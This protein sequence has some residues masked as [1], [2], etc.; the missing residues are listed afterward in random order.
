M[1]QHFVKKQVTKKEEKYN[2]M[3]NAT[4]DDEL[5]E[6]SKL[7]QKEQFAFIYQQFKNLW[8]STPDKQVPGSVEN[9]SPI[10]LEQNFI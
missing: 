7:I 9:G 3:P 2:A 5:Y 1:N 8:G 6:Y 4:H 10:L